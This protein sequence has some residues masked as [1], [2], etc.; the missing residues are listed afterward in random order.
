MKGFMTN[1]DWH[2]ERT[3]SQE[4]PSSLEFYYLR[5]KDVLVADPEVVGMEAAFNWTAL[6]VAWR[7]QRPTRSML[8]HVSICITPIWNSVSPII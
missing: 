5:V 6:E 2:W 4:I 1:P 7:L 8:F 3:Y